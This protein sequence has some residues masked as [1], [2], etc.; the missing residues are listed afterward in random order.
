METQIIA[1]VLAGW[2]RFDCALDWA[3]NDIVAYYINPAGLKYWQYSDGT[4]DTSGL[5]FGIVDEAIETGL[6]LVSRYDGWK[7]TNDKRHSST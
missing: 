2:R 5:S 6:L 4:W 7:P 3:A 1:D